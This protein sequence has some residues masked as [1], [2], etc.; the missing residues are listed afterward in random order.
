M[1]QQLLKQIKA[2]DFE[3]LNQVYQPLIPTLSEK[4]FT[5][6]QFQ[7]WIHDMFTQ[8]RKIRRCIMQWNDSNESL[9]PYVQLLFVFS[10]LLDADKSEAGIMQKETW[11]FSDR[12]CMILM[13]N[14]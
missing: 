6:S 14:V 13:R 10:L 1:E 4:P 7:Q 9:A 8:G 3:Q 2:I 5:K 11:S 12:L